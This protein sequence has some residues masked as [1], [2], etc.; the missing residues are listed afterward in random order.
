MKFCMKSIVNRIY[1]SYVIESVAV[2]E[3]RLLASDYSQASYR[4]NKI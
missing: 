3:I 1:E 2:L 4:F